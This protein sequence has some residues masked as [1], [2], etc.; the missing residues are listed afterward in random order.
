MP[1][2]KPVNN[3]KYSRRVGMD[4]HVHGLISDL[5]KKLPGLLKNYQVQWIENYQV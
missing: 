3:V 1:G 5:V 4:V 2:K